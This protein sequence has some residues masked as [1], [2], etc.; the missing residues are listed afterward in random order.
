MKRKLSFLVINIAMIFALA[1][2]FRGNIYAEEISS[3]SDDIGYDS[4]EW[5]VDDVPAELAEYFTMSEYEARCVTDD[6]GNQVWY[7]YNN[8]EGTRLKITDINNLVSASEQ[9]E[10]DNKKL[11]ASLQITRAALCIVTVVLL[12]IIAG[13]AYMLAQS[14]KKNP[15]AKKTEK[16]KKRRRD[17]DVDD[18]GKSGAVKYSEEQSR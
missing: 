2:V 4:D 9:M 8:M 16:K 11:N 1:F 10:A 3:E 13:L 6:N 18:Y 17:V 7:L 15:D 5:I 12:G 14:K